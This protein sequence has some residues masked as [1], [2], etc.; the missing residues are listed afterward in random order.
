MGTID[1]PART[2]VGDVMLLQHGH[3]GG[4]RASH[5]PRA[6]H[7]AGIPLLF[8]AV[9]GDAIDGH[10]TG[11]GEHRQHNSCVLAAGVHGHRVPG[12]RV[13]LR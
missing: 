12:H 11:V 8:C 9:E 5:V 2:G 4:N 6:A 1:V 3:A 7:V 13:L 10:R